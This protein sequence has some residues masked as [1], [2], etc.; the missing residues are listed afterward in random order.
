MNG[1]I[2][3]EENIASTPPKWQHPIL[4][5]PATQGNIL[6]TT[7]PFTTPPE[8]SSNF[9]WLAMEDIIGTAN[10]KMEY[11]EKKNEFYFYKAKG[12][13]DNNGEWHYEWEK[14]AVVVGISEETQ[15]ELQNLVYVSY[16]YDTDIANTLKVCGVKK[17]GELQLLCDITFVTPQEFAV[18]VNNLTNRI[19]TEES[20]ATNRENEI[21]SN[22]NNEITR[23]TNRENEIESNLNNE[24]IRATN[25]ELDLQNQI[26]DT[27]ENLSEYIG[28]FATKA[29]LEAYS[30]TAHNNDY[31]VVLND[32]THDGQCWRYIYKENTH[33]W[34]AQYMVNEE[35]MTQAQ[36]AALNS[37]ITAEKVAQIVQN[38]QDIFEIKNEIGGLQDE[39]TAGNGIDININNNVISVKGGNGIDVN[40]NGINVTPGDTIQINSDKVEVKPYQG[41]VKTNSGLSTNNGD[42]ITFD[43][44]NKI[45]LNTNLAKSTTELGDTPSGFVLH[46]DGKLEVQPGE[47]IGNM[48]WSRSSNLFGTLTNTKIK[49]HKLFLLTLQLRKDTGNW[50]NAYSNV[51]SVDANASQLVAFTSPVNPY[52]RDSSGNTKGW[53]IHEMEL[54]VNTIS[55]TISQVTKGQWMIN[56][57]DAGTPALNWEI[58]TSIYNSTWSGRIRVYGI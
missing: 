51:V 41:I 22:L 34:L 26:N 1:Q 30:G 33:S 29:A 42:G 23:A 44:N 36:I 17:D 6:I 45:T 5:A 58:A 8:D 31:A 7:T 48:T 11:D 14:F 20:R 38:K 25:R 57:W 27:K 12:H 53:M 16:I 40:A 43:S 21:E 50:E 54:T 35:P 18:A 28:N 37:S 56:P 9:K 24:I 49:R 13:L 55:G 10:V 39:L 32:E 47:Y 46:S 3:R 52:K 4:P 19:N 2:V 15:R